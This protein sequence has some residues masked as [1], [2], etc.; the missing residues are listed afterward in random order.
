MKKPYEW[1]LAWI[2]AALALVSAPAAHA[3]TMYY[4]DVPALVEA[5]DVVV[6]GEVVDADVFIGNSGR[7]TT[8]WTVDVTVTLHGDAHRQIRFR[9]WTGELD[10]MVQHI[11]GDGR[12]AVGDEVV[13]FL[14]GDAP[15]ALFLSALGQ[16]VYHV[17]AD[18]QASG[19]LDGVPSPI[20][21]VLTP[22]NPRLEVG[23]MP[24]G[25]PVTRDFADIGI[26]RPDGTV[27]EIGAL[28]MLTLGALMDAVQDASNAIGQGEG[29]NE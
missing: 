25:A 4:L 14:H 29:D 11:P 7:I 23:A 13:L 28:E 1:S 20:E 19:A 3:A 21:G 6:V 18:P 12:V 15:D 16:S 22:S 8:E 9:Q 17:H 26:Y 5:S 24:I 2:V 27:G 10:G